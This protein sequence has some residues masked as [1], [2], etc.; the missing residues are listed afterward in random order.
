MMMIRMKM[1][2]TMMKMIAFEL[3]EV[4]IIIIIMLILILDMEDN[5]MINMIEMI[6]LR[7]EVSIWNSNVVIIRAMLI[8]LP[9]LLITQ[10]DLI[11][12]VQLVY[13]ITRWICYLAIRYLWHDT[14]IKAPFHLIN[15]PHTRRLAHWA[16]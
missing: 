1:T 6:T 11:Q 13:Q 2:M 5:I 10:I 15:L 12:P 4:V 3:Y 16:S 7:D 9:T 8:M 14:P